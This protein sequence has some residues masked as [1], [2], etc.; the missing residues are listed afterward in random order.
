LIEIDNIPSNGHII[1]MAY[2]KEYTNYMQNASRKLLLKS[3]PKNGK[4]AGINLKP[5]IFGI[6]RHNEFKVSR[7]IGVFYSFSFKDMTSEKYRDFDRILRLDY[8][9]RKQVQN[10]WSHFEIMVGA[11]VGGI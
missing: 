10:M 9:K 5:Q 8:K 7:P 11:P 3:I 6:I 4:E 2:F 1:I